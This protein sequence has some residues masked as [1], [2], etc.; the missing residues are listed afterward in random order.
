MSWANKYIEKLQ[1][2]EVVQF[3]PHGNSMQGKIESGNLVTIEPIKNEL[4]VGDIVL[5]KVK[6]KQYVH[7]VTAIE[8]NKQFQI[9]NNKGYVNGWIGPS[10]IYG[11]CTKVEK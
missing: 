4:N 3:R 5:C 1:Q 8:N 10:S 6:G 9:S 2:G 7:L 11:I